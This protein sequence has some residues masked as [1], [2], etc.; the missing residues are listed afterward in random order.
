MAPGKIDAVVEAVR[1]DED[2]RVVSARIYEKRGPTWSDRVLIDRA[3]LVKR[4]RKGQRLFTGSRIAQMGG[5]FEIGKPL[6]LRKVKDSEILLAGY[7]D[8]GRDM[9]DGVPLF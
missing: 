8:T 1:Y 9:L 4:I 5:T 7:G 6:R 2:G 3:D